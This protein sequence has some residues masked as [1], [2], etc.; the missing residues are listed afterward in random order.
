[1]SRGGLHVACGVGRT[2]ADDERQV[3]GLDNRGNQLVVS[4]TGH[5]GGSDGEAVSVL[6][7]VRTSGCRR[8]CVVL[9]QRPER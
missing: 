1:M 9:Q 5:K 3:S 6:P 4:L 7:Y 8:D 2:I